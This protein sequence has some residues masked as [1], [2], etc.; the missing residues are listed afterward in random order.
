MKYLLIAI[1][2]LICVIIALGAI[3]IVICTM[4]ANTHIPGEWEDRD[5]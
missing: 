5:E 1:A 3:C 2:M 4:G